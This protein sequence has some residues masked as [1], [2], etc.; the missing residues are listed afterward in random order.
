MKKS[1]LKLKKSIN[2]KRL[3]EKISKLSYKKFFLS[4][5]ILGLLLGVILVFFGT[6]IPSLIT[7]SKIFG[8]SF[9]TSTG[10]FLI[11]L[12]SLPGYLIA[13]NLMSFMREIPW[14]ISLMIVV[15]TSGLFYFFIGFLIDKK[16]KKELD[17]ILISKIIIYI[18]FISL[19]ILLFSLLRSANL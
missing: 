14:S 7:C 17:L 1:L 8:V 10:V 15:V 18:S 9:C 6:F 3:R 5:Y 12:L 11:L 2:F 13:G 16:R 4:L 19:T